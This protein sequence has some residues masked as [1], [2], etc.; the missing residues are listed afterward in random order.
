MW[1]SGLL[2]GPRAGDEYLVQCDEETNPLEERN[3]GLVQ[4]KVVLRPIGTTEY[5]VVELRL[6]ANEGVVVTS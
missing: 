4:V 3:A 6:G 2:T 5:I 1:G